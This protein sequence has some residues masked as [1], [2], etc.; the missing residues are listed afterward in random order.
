MSAPVRV[1]L[2]GCGRI[3]RVHR[4]YLQGLPQVEL[5][6]VFDQ[7]PEARAAFSAE[8]G[9]AAHATIEELLDQGRPQVVHVLTPPPSHAVVAQTILR[10]GVNVLVEKPMTLT[11]AEAD[12]LIE[13][14]AAHGCW[15]TVDHNRWFD[16]IVQEAARLLESGRLGSL[17]GV[18]VFQGA[19]AGEADK[20]QRAEKHWTVQLPGGVLL[21]LAS[22]PLYLMRRFAG[23]VRSLKVLAHHTGGVHLEEVHLVAEGER[24]L[25]SVTMSLRAQPFM[26]RL[27]LLGTAASLEVNLNNM[28]LIERRPR[29]LPKLIGKIWPNLS[30]AG[31]LVGA[32]V[33]NGIGYLT[34]KQRYYPGIGAHLRGLY[35][36]LAAG[37]GPLVD[38]EEGRDIVAHYEEILR[39]SGIAVAA[40][41]PAS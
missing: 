32:T 14:A 13:T 38:A 40:A 28:T 35:E 9:L 27:V 17:V 36:S 26:N 5:V 34:G 6:G 39:Q 12:G 21:N 18:Q 10:A 11:T 41:E 8:T 25:A 16:P 31:Q 19:E 24:A 33:R 2:V 4:N 37:G 3:A 30:E 15:V 20:R 7:V 23:P 22:H 29:A 1:G